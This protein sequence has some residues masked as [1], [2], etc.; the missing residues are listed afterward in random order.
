MSKSLAAVLLPLALLGGCASPLHLTYDHGRAFTESFKGQA[1]LTRPAVANSQ[2]PLYGKEAA[3]I[4]L[5]VET[6]A[7]STEDT[8]ST[9][10]QGAN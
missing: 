9:L 4:R 7:S 1:D 3:A 8:S 2:Y 10:Q 6:E 5:Q